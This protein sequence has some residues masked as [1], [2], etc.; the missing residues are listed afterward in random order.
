M[1]STADFAAKQTIFVFANKGQK[2]SF[3]NDNLILKDGDNKTILQTTCYR[4]FCVFIIGNLSLTTGIIQRA[5]KFKFAIVLMTVSMRPYQ[6]IGFRQEGNTLLRKRQYDY[7]GLELAKYFTGNKI[8]NQRALL[9]KQRNK[10]PEL[11]KAIAVLDRYNS[12]ISTAA[13][14]QEIMGYE[15]LAAKIYF[16]NHF[17]NIEWNGR[18]PRIKPDMIN[19]LLDIGY[20]LLF[21]FIEAILSIYGFDLYNGF[22]HRF[23]Y[24]RKS[25]VCDFVEP[26]RVLIDD[27]VKKG[28]NLRQFKE[29]DF[30]TDRQRFDLQWKKSAEYTAVLMH[31]ILDNKD[32]IFLYIQSFY[33]AFVNGRNLDLFPVYDFASGEVVK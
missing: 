3:Q 17:N 11:K 6:I 1:I 25:L 33:R 14:L 26:F 4:I 12:N 31:P 30:W 16:Q 15:G 7:G 23:F 13:T 8:Q 28:I 24:M 2:M 27:T 20:T 29:E 21:S 19:S 32:K 10:S 9:N 5:H 22:L 18:R